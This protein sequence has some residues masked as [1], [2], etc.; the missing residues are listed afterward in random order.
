MYIRDLRIKKRD[1]SEGSQ[2]VW[3]RQ[4]ICVSARKCSNGLKTQYDSAECW[5]LVRWNYDYTNL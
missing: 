4:G 5:S 1:F 2:K 3:D